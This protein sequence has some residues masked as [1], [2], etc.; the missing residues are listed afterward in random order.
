MKRDHHYQPMIA[1][2]GLALLAGLCITSCAETGS[3]KPGVYSEIPGVTT[4]A[5]PAAAPPGPAAPAA[6]PAPQPVAAAPAQPPE[7]PPVADKTLAAFKATDL[8]LKS[9]LAAFAR[10][11]DLNIVPDNDVTGTVT[12]DVHNLPLRQMMRALLEASDCT[13]HEEGGLIR[14]RNTETRTFNIDY[15]RL[16][17]AGIG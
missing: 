15:L 12:L 4:P 13:W 1:S 10:D 8:D 11:N 6:A 3:K 7:A 16:A 17:R 5:V 9:A 2:A 14:V